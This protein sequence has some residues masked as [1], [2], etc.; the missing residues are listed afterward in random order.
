MPKPID[1]YYWPTPNGWKISI[2]LE[3]MKLPYEVK[4]V[5]I[6]A[7]DQ[8][9]PDFLKIAPNNRMPAIVDPDGPDGAP[10]SI[11]ESGAILQYLARK[12][13]TFCGETERD[14]IAVDQ[15]LMWQMGGLGPM[16]GQAHHF[17][18]Y[19]P[20]MEPP[21]DLPYA[22]DRYRAETA[23]LYGV[24][25]RQLANNRYLAGDFYSIADMACWG[26]ASLWEGQEQTLD[27]KPN[28][29]RWLEEVGARPAVQRGRALASD[30]RGNLQTDKKAQEVLFKR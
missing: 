8:F 26:W 11:F 16:A 13:G 18:K 7:G 6:G 22:K 3:E 25:D 1:L 29:A 15:W 12:T 24:M 2:A 21:N 14:R 9:D 28:L 10:I 23:R 30:Q 27:D 17:L 5:N 19:A 4:L 20:S